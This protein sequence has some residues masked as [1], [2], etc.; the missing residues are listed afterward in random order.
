MEWMPIETAPRDGTEFQAW[1]EP[2]IADGYWIPVCKFES[3][4]HKNPKAYLFESRE[5]ISMRGATHWMPLPAP[6]NPTAPQ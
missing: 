2:L 5:Y 4:S 6:P 1:V 3:P